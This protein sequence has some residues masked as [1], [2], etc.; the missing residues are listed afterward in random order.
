[1]RS[2]HRAPREVDHGEVVLL[3]RDEHLA[4][5]VAHRQPMRGRTNVDLLDR[6]G[7]RI[8]RQHRVAEFARRPERAGLSIITPCGA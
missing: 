2:N 6:L 7:R 8:D 1:M 4:G 3:H 5:G